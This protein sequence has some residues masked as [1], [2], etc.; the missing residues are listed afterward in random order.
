[1][2]YSRKCAIPYPASGTFLK[3]SMGMCVLLTI[4]VE[5]WKVIYRKVPF[6]RLSL[7]ALF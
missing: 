3:A 1:M 5:I 2:L 4:E 6:Y 7:I